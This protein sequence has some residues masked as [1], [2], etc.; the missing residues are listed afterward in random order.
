MA[1]DNV[2]SVRLSVE[3]YLDP[4][5]L[6][7]V[8]QA[9]QQHGRS[10]RALGN[11]YKRPL[12]EITGQVTEFS[13]SLDA[14]NARVLAFG[15]SAGAIMGLQRAFSYL[16]DS[17]IKVEKELKDINVILGAN[18]TQLQGFSKELFNVAGNTGQS[19]QTVATAAKELSRQGLSME[20]T[21][22]RTRDA[23][24]LTRLSGMDAEAA[25]AS[26]TAAINTFNRSALNSTQ[27]V[28][29]MANVDAAFA[30][31]TK[32]LAEA[33]KLVGSTAQYVQVDFNQLLGAVAS[34]QQ[35]T[36]RGGTVIGNGL[37]SIF[38]R[39]QRTDTLDQLESLGVAVRNLQGEMLPAMTVLCNLAKKFPQLTRA[40]QAHTA[41]TVAGV[42]QMNTLRALLSDLGKSHS[43][44]AK[45]VQTSASATNEAIARNE[46]LNKTLD[47]QII[48]L[49]A[50]LMQAGKGLGGAILGPSAQKLVSGLNSMFESGKGMD[51][52]AFGVKMAKGMLKGIGSFLAGPGLALV[53]VIGAQ[54]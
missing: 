39:I 15:A 33:M 37:K 25:V 31:S 20:K 50:H 6:R 19:F 27:I 40:Q 48:K 14:S 36:A 26:L 18:K 24:I 41:E 51:G 4:K 11:A 43:S 49:K 10:A 53:A 2:G 9:V 32:Y 17:M 30:V 28:N 21:L 46:E 5:S 12:G 47:A 42:L 13:K 29:K 23:L 52:E 38:T 54:S 1:I 45:A 34:L 8:E 44:Y 7:R 22:L 3:A 35:T 16:L